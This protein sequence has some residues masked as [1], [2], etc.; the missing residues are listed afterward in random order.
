[1]PVGGGGMSAGVA[2]AVKR[3][4]PQARVIGVEPTGSPK[5]TRAREAGRPV[6]L[7]HTDSIADGLLSIRIGT[8]PFAH[9]EAF[10]D[11]VVMV[12]DNAIRDAMRYLLDRAKLVAEPSGAITVAALRTGAVRASGDTVAVLS[13]GNVE[14]PGLRQLLE[15]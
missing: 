4:A 14:W 10:L 15:G 3:L 11:D 6:T 9:H 13:G 12:D 5:L 1:M 7:D 8:I 2:A